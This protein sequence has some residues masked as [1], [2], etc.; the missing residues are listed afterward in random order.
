MHVMTKSSSR[1]WTLWIKRSKP[2]V[3]LLCLLPAALLTV[4]IFTGNISAD[5]VEDI[6]HITGEWGLRLLL[7]TLAVTPLR[8]ITGINQLIMLRRMLGVYAFFYILLHFL[9]YLVIDNFFDFQRIVEDIIERYYILFGTLAFAAMIPLA[10][11]S[12]NRMLKALGGKR[13]AKLHKLIYP[14]AILSV[15]HFYLQVKADITQ[16]V[17]YGSILA[18]LLAYRFFKSR[19]QSR[20]KSAS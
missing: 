1:Q 11:T 12:T 7:L 18:V 19:R 10:A 2:F 20:L 5:P 16:P 8:S 6:T 4:N 9:T 14:I 3:F 17:I 13:W 15:V